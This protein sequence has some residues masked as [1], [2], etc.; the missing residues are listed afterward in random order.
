MKGSS[1]MMFKATKALLAGAALIGLSVGSAHAYL[2]E[3]KTF[4][5]RAGSA[6]SLAL[7]DVANDPAARALKSLLATPQGKLSFNDKRDRAAMVEFYA[8]RD[9]QPV[10]MVEGVYTAQARRIMDRIAAAAEDGLDPAAYTLPPATLGSSTPAGPDIAASVDLLLSKAVLT[11]ARQAY[12]G[13]LDPSSISKLIT[14]KPLLPD[15]IEVLTTVSTASDGAGA[16]A[17]YNPQHEG[18]LRL[19]QALATARSVETPTVHAPLPSG[20]SMKVGLSDPR[21]PLLRAR[22]DLPAPSEAPEVYDETLAQ[23]VKSFQADKGLKADGIAGNAT[24]AFI[25]G[26]GKS[27][28][29]EIIANMERWRWMPRDLGA[30]HII[31]N[32]PEYNVRVVENGKVIHTTRSVVGKITNQTPV[33]SDAMES[34]VVNP[35]WNVPAS[36]TMK[37]MLPAVRRDPSYMSRKGYQVLANVDGKFRPVDPQMVDWSNVNAR[38]IMIRQ[39]PGDDNALG[40]V[41]FLFPNEHAVYL[42]DTPSKSFFKRDDRALSHG[43]VR[44]QDPLEFADV[45]LAHQ[46]GWSQQRLRKMVGGK[47]KW[48][49]LPNRIPIHL[50]YFTAFVDDNGDVQTRPDIYG[51]NARVEKA[52]GLQG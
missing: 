43:C 36:I 4:R 5:E 47:E 34:I 13:R 16:I 28:T 44:V 11:Y 1:E 35:S 32:I 19:K 8:E 41:K 3:G 18:Y 12:A 27:N 37:E 7:A 42:H 50:T 33:F 20:K 49:N 21:V 15:P 51:F 14:L 31:A 46:G 40:N 48:I 39:P 9:Y 26:T 22:F 30:F 25:N 6:A 38:Q 17:A 52:L 10:W 2:P 29:A 23:A 45:L 24:V